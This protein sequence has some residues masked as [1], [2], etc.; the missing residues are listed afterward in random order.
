M[1]RQ[2]LLSQVH[3]RPEAIGPQFW[4]QFMSTNLNDSNFNNQDIFENTWNKGL[5]CN[6]LD[7]FLLFFFSLLNTGNK[8]LGNKRQMEN[9]RSNYKAR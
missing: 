1:G 7:F 9:N 2:C 6:L 5:F 4:E 8:L 3:S